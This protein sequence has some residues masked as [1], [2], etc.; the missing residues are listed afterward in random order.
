MATHIVPIA[1]IASV[2]LA[3]CA[4]TAGPVSQTASETENL[5]PCLA[6]AMEF[7][8][9]TWDYTS[10]IARINGEYRTFETRSVHGQSDERTWTSQSFGGDIEEEEPV[11]FERLRGNKTFA[12]VDG[13]EMVA[14]ARTFQTCDAPNAVGRILTTSTYEFPLDE[15]GTQIAFVENF[16]TF[17]ETGTYFSEEIRNADGEIIAYRAGVT[18]PVPE[19]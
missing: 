15:D 2:C 9:G 14:E 5:E 1:L 4:S 10:V 16:A 13:E 12:V 11:S 8:N 7:M 18:V 3:S 17:S 19:D 6:Q